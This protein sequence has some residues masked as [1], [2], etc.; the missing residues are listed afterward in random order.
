MAVPINAPLP[1]NLDLGP[2]FTLR[3]TALDTTNGNV[4]SGVTV[5]NFAV[6]LEGPIDQNQSLAYGP[7]MLVPG[8]S[9]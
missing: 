3:V 9:A 2:G 4:V 5:S 6:L 8:P 7:F 1:Q